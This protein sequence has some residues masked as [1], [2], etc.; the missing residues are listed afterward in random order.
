MTVL[1]EVANSLLVFIQSNGKISSLEGGVAVS[2][3]L[4]GDFEDVGTLEGG[5]VGLVFWEIFVGVAGGVN[6]LLGGS[7]GR[8]TGE[9]ATVWLMTLVS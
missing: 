9:E 8:I 2:F 4:G 3:E 5:G 1:V 7:D 6:G